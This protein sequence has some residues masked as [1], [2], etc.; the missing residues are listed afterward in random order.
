MADGLNPKRSQ[1]VAELLSDFRSLQHQIASAP[2]E[3]QDPN[4]TRSAGWTLLLQCVLNGQRILE[5]G[6]DTQVP[7]GP[8]SQNSEE[9]QDKAELRQVHLDAFS[10]RHAAQKIRLRQLAALEWVERRVDALR[11][12]GDPECAAFLRA[13]DTHL[14]NVVASITDEVV[15]GN[16]RRTDSQRGRWINED[17]SL[18]QVQRWISA[19]ARQI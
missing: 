15:Y 5:C 11:R 6:A 10:R 3:P 12:R 13:S 17:P 1:R 16:M 14:A 9:E 8:R 19:R 7:R 18:I 2:A 4:E